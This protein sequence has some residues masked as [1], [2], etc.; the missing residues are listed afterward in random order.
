MNLP[1]KQKSPTFKLGPSSL[2]WAHSSSG[3]LTGPFLTGPLLRKPYFSPLFLFFFLFFCQTRAFKSRAPVLCGGWG[4][5][6]RQ[7][8]ERC[9]SCGRRAG[10]GGGSCGRPATLGP[11]SW[12]SPPCAASSPA[13]SA[14]ASCS[15]P[16]PAPTS[17]RLASARTLAPNPSCVS[18]SSLFYLFPSSFA[19]ASLM[20]GPC[21]SLPPHFASSIVIPPLFSVFFL[22]ML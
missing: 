1:S 8:R 21:F 19:S 16:A 7:H 18:P 11:S 22:Q 5:T 6:S 17:S 15:S 10:L 4:S 14:T 2:L 12:P 13:S 20:L 3:S 9:R